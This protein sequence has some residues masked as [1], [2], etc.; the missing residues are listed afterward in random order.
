VFD[1]LLNSVQFLSGNHIK[2]GNVVFDSPLL[3]YT[4]GGHFQSIFPT[5]HEYFIRYARELEE[6]QDTN[7]PL[8]TI[9]KSPKTVFE[10]ED[11]TNNKCS[12]PQLTCNESKFEKAKKVI[13][14]ASKKESNKTETIERNST[15]E[16]PAKK[17]KYD[18]E[19]EA[20]IKS[21]KAKDRT[22]ED[23]KKLERFRKRIQRENKTGKKTKSQTGTGPFANRSA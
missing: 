21:I 19:I 14:K 7:A 9:T 1:L 3:I 11:H 17:N 2:S 16:P 5:D 6:K 18:L 22:L 4:T 10:T 23:R 15:V 8:V 20:D 12:S 13:T